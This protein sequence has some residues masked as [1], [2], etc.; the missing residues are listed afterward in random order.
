MEELRFGTAGIPYSTKDSNTINGIK[1]VK[2]LG[3]GA[4]ELEFVRSV[5]IKKDFEKIKQAAKSNN[6]VLTCHGQYYVNLNADTKKKLEDSKNRILNAARTA[7]AC[8]AWSVCFHPAYYL[9]KEP[10][11]VYS[12]VRK[13]I[14]FLS[15]ILLQEGN[16][17]WLRPETTG[18]PT[19]FGDLN[20]L[21]SISSEFENVMPCIDFSHL[22]SRTGG[23][24]NTY[25]E[26]WKSLSSVEKFLGR[27]GLD[28]MHIHLAG[29]EY[30]QKG[31]IRHLNLEDSDLQY[32]EL[33]AAWKD[34]KIKGVVICES[35]NIEDDAQL[36]KKTYLYLKNV[37]PFENAI[38]Q[39]KK[40]DKEFTTRSAKDSFEL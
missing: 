1:K 28:N 36:L 4:M 16:K 20:E 17:I 9:K 30:S 33:L 31:E 40:Y 7:F 12:E 39:L 24:F 6:V 34:F 25:N 23:K 21:L 5:N 27:K 10:K 18:K 35:P 29:I 11:L 2:E 38:N 22:H 3:L 14:Q 15:E 8:G 32:E 13:H 37:D 26:F 19:Q